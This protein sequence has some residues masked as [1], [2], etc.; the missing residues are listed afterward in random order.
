MFTKRNIVKKAKTY[1]LHKEEDE[2]QK[3]NEDNTTF[4][5]KKRTLTSNNNQ[6]IKQISLKK[7][8]INQLLLLSQTTQNQMQFV[9]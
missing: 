8:S 1:K 2:E 6:F 5:N 9:K 3:Q 4:L 7:P